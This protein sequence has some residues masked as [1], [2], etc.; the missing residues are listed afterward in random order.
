MEQGRPGARQADDEERP[1]NRLLRDFGIA[2]AIV[3]EPKTLFEQSEDVRASRDTPE[4]RQACFGLAS[5]DQDV[6]RLE[7]VIVSE[8]MEA[9]TADGAFE[10]LCRVNAH[11]PRV[12]SGKPI[13][14]A[15]RGVRPMKR[16]EA[17]PRFARLTRPQRLPRE[18]KVDCPR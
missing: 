11:A 7:K 12:W 4:E 5:A 3:L 2:L 1:P 8:I 15:N 13:G 16:R 6:K 14:E 17:L 10:E 18:R 9:R